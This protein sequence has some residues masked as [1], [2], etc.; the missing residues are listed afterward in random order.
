MKWPLKGICLLFAGALTISAS[1]MAETKA[2]GYLDRADVDAFINEL[3]KEEKFTRKELENIIG[4]AEKSERALAL[5]SR[6]AEGTLEWKD[7]RKIF[8]TPERVEKGVKFW[9]ENADTLIR[10]EKEYG[11]PPQI[12]VAIIGVETYYGRQTG[13]FKVLDTLTTLGFDFPRRSEFFRKELKN[14]FILAREQNLD[15]T[16]LTG[17][18][19]GAMGIP[20]F[21]PSSYR[22]YAVDYTA[23]KQA[24]IWQTEE[25]AI[26][27]VANYL[28]RHG[29]KKDKPVAS[30]AKVTGTNYEKVLSKGL[31]PDKKLS[32]AG[33]SGWSPF[34]VI[35][36]SSKV[37]AMKMQGQDG[38]EYWL[39]MNNFYVVT[40]YNRS[41]M[42]ALAVHQLARAVM[43]DYKKTVQKEK[44]ATSS[45][46]KI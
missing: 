27:S 21:M 38:P 13:G 22:A 11:V 46:R 7:Y 44:K 29:W 37:L 10:V 41:R 4:Q 5:I 19:A 20:Q 26:A 15:I 34:N 14:L 28:S 40:R 30:R 31:K 3:V 43:S 32:Q 39:G 36:P 8:M 25:D 17:S 12:I 35:P 18:Y 1:A 24:N 16:E 42:Y 9:Q 33:K 45:I 6:P 2:K 23:D